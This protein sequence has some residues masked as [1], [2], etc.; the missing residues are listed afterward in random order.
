MTG[1]FCG[2]LT[3]LTA[4]F[5]SVVSGSLVRYLLGLRPARAAATALATTFFGALTALTTYSHHHKVSW[6]VGALLAITQILGVSFAE[7]RAL[8]LK[9]TPALRMFWS[10][11]GI[12]AGVAMVACSGA[13]ATLSKHA[14]A[15]PI[16]HTTLG[17]FAW[18]VLVG[19]V[20][21]ALSQIMDLGGVLI[22]PACLL[23]LG[24]DPTMAQGT[25]LF[26]LLLVSL[27]GVLIY[28]RT[29]DIDFGSVAWM[30]LGA[31]FG[32]LVGA[33][34]VFT[35]L[36]PPMVVS[37]FGVAFALIA[38]GRFLGAGTPREQPPDGAQ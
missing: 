25:A 23:L 21:G 32:G 37:V 22:V 28:S 6:G 7:R 5:G 38:V 10:I 8:A 9:S 26:G 15:I 12:A 34:V 31:L 17:M 36:S 19:V 24:L 1:L 30:S 29:G 4:S 14:P 16:L 13:V 27:P 33:W 11:L 18:I 3:G 20:V 2:T 35:K